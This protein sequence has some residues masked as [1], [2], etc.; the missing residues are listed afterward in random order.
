MPQYVSTTETKD[1]FWIVEQQKYFKKIKQV[2]LSG[3]ALKLSDTTKPFR[4]YVDEDGEMAKG[5]FP[6]NFRY[7]EMDGGLFIKETGP[8]D[9][10]T[11]T[12]STCYCSYRTVG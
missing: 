11:A 4:L 10:S 5:F 12:S 3:P 9:C 8:S 2:L 1:V 6:Q 7:R